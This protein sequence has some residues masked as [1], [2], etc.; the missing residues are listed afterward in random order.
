MAVGGKSL[1]EQLMALTNPEPSPFDHLEEEHDGL[2]ARLVSRDDVEWEAS[3]FEAV[4]RNCDSAF[5]SGAVGRR[6]AAFLDEEDSRYLGRVTSRHKIREEWPW[7][8]DA[9]GQ[10][11]GSTHDVPLDD[12]EPQ[13]SDDNEQ[14][15]STE[16]ERD[17]ETSDENVD[18][19]ELEDNIFNQ[20]VQETA[21]DVRHFSDQ[22]LKE[23]WEKGLAVKS[24]LKLWDCFLEARIKLQKVLGISNQFPQQD[25]WDDFQLKGGPELMKQLQRSQ[26]RLKTLLDSLLSLQQCLL[27]NNQDYT[28]TATK[29]RA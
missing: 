16:G 19:L 26:S 9:R 13:D 24:Q 25:V 28:Q 7:D 15:S 6:A 3:Q 17:V 29:S 5:E 27:E 14:S 12:M 22:N 4:A 11:R 8:D 23:E 1:S 21:G 20:Q 2:S 10:A 18:D